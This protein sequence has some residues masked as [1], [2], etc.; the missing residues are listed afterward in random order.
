M[1]REGFAPVMGDAGEVPILASFGDPATE[2]RG[3]KELRELVP[4]V[5][6]VPRERGV[7]DVL[8]KVLGP[9]FKMV[10]V[11]FEDQRAAQESLEVTPAD[12]TPT[13][14]RYCN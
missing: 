12:L 6:E 9:C 13:E 8:L 3:F 1:I 2:F 7:G 4:E 10:H 11:G 5:T 14:R